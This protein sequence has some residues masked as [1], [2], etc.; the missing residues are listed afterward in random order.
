MKQRFVIVGASAGGATA[1]AELRARGFGGEIA[2]V[3]SGPELPHERPPLSRD[4]LPVRPGS[5]PDGVARVAPDRV[6]PTREK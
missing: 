6:A 2:L 3:G 5:T 1:A 4:Y